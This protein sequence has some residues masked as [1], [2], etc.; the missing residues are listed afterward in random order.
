MQ[1]YKTWIGI[2]ITIMGVFGLGYLVTGD[3]LAQ[4]VDSALKIFGILMTIYGNYKAHQ[5]I[6]EL[7]SY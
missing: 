2:I 1:G 4:V 7:K 3:Q 5:E 6:K